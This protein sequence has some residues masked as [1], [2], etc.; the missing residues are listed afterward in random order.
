MDAAIY[1]RNI[2]LP[3]FLFQL[4]LLTSVTTTV[5]LTPVLIAMAVLMLLCGY[6]ELLFREGWLALT[7]GDTYWG[8]NFKDILA[9]GSLDRQ[10]RETGLVFLNYRDLFRTQLFN[11]PLLGDSG[12]VMRLVGPNMSVIPFGYALSFFCLFLMAVG[13]WPVA[14]LTLPLLLFVSAKGPVVLIIF[15]VAALISTRLFGAVATLVAIACA[16]IA[17]GIIGIHTGVQ[18]GDYH[19]IGFMGGLNGFFSN[20]LGRGLGIG[21]NLS[22]GYFEIDWSKAQAAGAV[23]GAVESAIGVLLYQMGIGASVPLALFAWIGFSAW[24][25]Y[26][27]TGIAAQGVAAFGMFVIVFNGLFQEE[28]LFSPPA[29]G[30]IISFAG[31][32]IGNDIR[33]E[34]QW[35]ADA[36]KSLPHLP[37]Q[38]NQPGRLI[39]KSKIR[40]DRHVVGWLLPAPH[41]LVDADAGEAIA[42]LRRQQQMIDSDALVLLIGPGLIIPESVLTGFVGDSA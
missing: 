7:N 36:I 19:A 12:E 32:V 25:L 18:A 6:F 20:P 3:I 34:S 38:C 1:L 15:V 35:K 17:Y 27:R 40:P 42:G 24:K 23:E 39:E 26:A 16:L 41:M 10:M 21:G 11:T 5:R 30:L 33:D 31:L 2:A 22:A 28:A 13:L 37:N 8:F 4:S 29:L 14:L 9:S